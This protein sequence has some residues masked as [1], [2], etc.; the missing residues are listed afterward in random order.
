MEKQQIFGHRLEQLLS[1][2]GISQGEFAEAVNCSRQSINFY[3]LGKRNPDIT[4]AGKMA[5]YLGVSCDY[6]VG[7]SDIRENKNANLTADQLGLTDDT[8]KFFAGLQLLATGKTNFMKKDYEAIGF[9]YEK[10]IIPYNMAQGKSTLKILNDLISHERFGILLQYIKRYKDIASGNDTM[11]IL[12]DFMVQLDS[13]LTGTIYG[14]KEENLDMMKEFCLHIVS[15]YFDE[16][17]KNIVS[18]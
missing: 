16:I 13:P 3:I 7:L 14:G 15:K 8:M 2:K 4:L 11:A 17:V 18:D 9:D 6:L 12:Q 1:E 10:E 5:E